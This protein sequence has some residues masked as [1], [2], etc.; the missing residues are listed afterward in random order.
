MTC[1][2]LDVLPDSGHSF[3]AV[4][5]F[6]HE[7]TLT[8]FEVLFFSVVDLIAQDFVL[9]AVLTFILMEVRLTSYS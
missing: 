8:I 4:L 2:F 9:A 1:V 6:G 3:D 7:T 5:F